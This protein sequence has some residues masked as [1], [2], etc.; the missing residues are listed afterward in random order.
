MNHCFEVFGLTSSRSVPYESSSILI[1][2]MS[3]A[4]LAGC[5][6]SVH[7]NTLHGKKF[8]IGLYTQTF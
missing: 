6:L 8:N 2:L 3:C 5:Y 1:C 7:P 4:H